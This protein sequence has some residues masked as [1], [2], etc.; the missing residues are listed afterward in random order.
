MIRAVIF[1]LDGTLVDAPSYNAVIIE[2]TMNSFGKKL[3]DEDINL[4]CYSNERDR[5]VR[6]IYNIEPKLFWDRLNMLDLPEVRR[7]FIEVYPDAVEV[8][9]E[10]VNRNYVLGI[11]TGSPRHIAE[12]SVGILGAH[13]FSAVVC[14]NPNNGLS[15]KPDPRGIEVCMAHLGVPAYKCV[16]IGNGGEDVEAAKSAKVLDVFLDRRQYDAAHIAA[17]HKISSL[18]EVIHILDNKRVFTK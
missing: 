9:Q 12:V 16:Y 4:I 10:L 15:R 7:P 8:L 5:V 1:D 14:A 13:F 6:D 17:S 3:R 2:K 18:T 11:V